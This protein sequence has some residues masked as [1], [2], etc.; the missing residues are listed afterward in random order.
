MS[1][2]KPVQQD[3]TIRIAWG[4]FTIPTLAAALGI[5]ITMLNLSSSYTERQ[6]KQEARID[7]MDAHIERVDAYID[8]VQADR[9][10]SK[11]AV[12][13]VTDSL[14]DQTA[15]IPLLEQRMADAEAD[16]KANDR[17]SEARSDKQLEINAK[18]LEAIADLKSAFG[19]LSTKFDNAWPDKRSELADT[20]AELVQR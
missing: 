4:T 15:K 14:A 19:Q 1:E 5:I 8:R 6:T 12:L 20:P 10:L 11:A 17:T 2:G 7:V 3:T 16:I 9:V 13:K 18:T